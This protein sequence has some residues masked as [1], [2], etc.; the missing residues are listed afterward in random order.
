[1]KNDNNDAHRA[2]LRDYRILYIPKKVRYIVTNI[3]PVSQLAKVHSDKTTAREMLIYFTAMVSSPYS[4]SHHAI[5]R[6]HSWHSR[7]L[8][9]I[10]NTSSSAYTRVIELLKEYGVI[11]VDMSYSVEEHKTRKYAL[12]DAYFNRGHDSYTATSPWLVELLR[13]QHLARAVNTGDNPIANSMMKVYPRI[14]LP[15]LEE[16]NAVADML[17]RDRVVLKGARCVRRGTRYKATKE[18]PLRNLDDDIALFTRLT[19]NGLLIPSISAAAGGRVCDSF[20]LMPSWIRAL[21][22][23]DGVNMA[24]LDYRCLHPNIIM[25]IYGES[26]VKYLSHRQ[27]SDETG[28]PLADVKV[29]HLSFFNRSVNDMKRRELYK[30]YNTHHPEMMRR[31]IADKMSSPMG[32][33]VTERMLMEKEV[34]MMTEVISRLDEMDIHGVYVYDALYVNPMH[35]EIVTSVMNDVALGHGVYTCVA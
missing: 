35:R 1:M 32:Y 2:G 16:I 19:E 34:Q 18:M 28:I 17:I 23:L 30:Y 7:G 26:R 21:V 12:S 24:A 31:L 8:Y 22:K 6:W 3:I 33:K 14:E 5:E 11:D 29:A 25:A 9:G 15:T 27:V 10:F 20:T 4:K 13:K